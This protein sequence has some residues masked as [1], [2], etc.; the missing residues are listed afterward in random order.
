MDFK[1]VF[2]QA[3][4][5]AMLKKPAMEAV[6]SDKGSLVPAFLMIGLVSLVSVL[7]LMAFPHTYGGGYIV[8]SADAG[9]FIGRFVW[10]V[11]MYAASLYLTGYL[12]L[13][14]FKSQLP[15]DGFVRVVGFGMIVMLVS[16]FPQLSF[17]GGIWTFVI[18]WK[19]L[20]ELGKL[21]PVEIIVLM[22]IDVILLGMLN[23][24]LVPMF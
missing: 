11:V 18:L 10:N 1:K 24:L 3:T 6:A 19:V 21:E 23:M 5:I 15:V 7:G 16:I 8:F 13:E 22:V 14:L 12:A 17:V 2:K 4:D 20:T 9:W